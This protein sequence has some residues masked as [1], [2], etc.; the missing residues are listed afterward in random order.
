MT[1][2]CRLRK[3]PLWLN[4]TGI[5]TYLFCFTLNTS[6]WCDVVHPV[7]QMYGSLALEDHLEV[8]YAVRGGCSRYRHRMRVQAP[9]PQK[10]G[11]FQFSERSEMVRIRTYINCTK[12]K[13]IGRL[14]LV[15]VA[16][17]APRH[18]IS[19]HCHSWLSHRP[20]THVS[21]CKVKLTFFQSAHEKAGR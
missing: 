13:K 12:S 20:S 18:S 8:G 21:L 3:K 17:A 5:W 10:K 4:Q 2:N 1:F 16:A 11:F 19:Y 14:G 7:A 15:G 6:R 9:N